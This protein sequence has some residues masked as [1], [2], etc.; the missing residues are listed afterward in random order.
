MICKC[1][2]SIIIKPH[3]YHDKIEIAQKIIAFVDVENGEAMKY[4]DR[5]SIKTTLYVLFHCIMSDQVDG[6]DDSEANTE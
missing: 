2:H 3:I 5:W 4:G 1:V 6:P